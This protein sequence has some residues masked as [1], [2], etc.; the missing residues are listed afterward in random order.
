MN[1]YE[2]IATRIENADKDF[3]EII[4]NISGCDMATARKVTA[5]Y[6]KNKLAKRDA[7]IGRVTVKH[8][9]YLDKRAIENAIDMIA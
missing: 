8:G 4:A 6:L 2:A 3:A 5:F 1:A 7:V 9:A